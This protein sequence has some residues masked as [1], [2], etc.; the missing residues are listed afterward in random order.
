M[1]VRVN[2]VVGGWLVGM[3]SATLHSAGRF[4]RLA[5][6]VAIALASIAHVG[7]DFRDIPVDRLAVVADV[8]SAPSDNSTDTSTTAERCHSCSIVPFVVAL[9]I[10]GIDILTPSVV[11]RRSPALVGFEQPSTAPPP[12]A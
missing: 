2:S 4:V 12:R 1:T 11:T 9:Q 7:L 3:T 10:V 8:M 5:C 6:I